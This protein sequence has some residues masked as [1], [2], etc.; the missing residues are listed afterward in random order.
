MKGEGGKC[1]SAGLVRGG[2]QSG[3]VQLISHMSN[4]Q[5][6]GGIFQRYVREL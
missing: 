5:M 3:R 2:N 1:T 6:K 4:V